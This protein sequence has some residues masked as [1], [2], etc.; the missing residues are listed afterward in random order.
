MVE[1]KIRE[2]KPRDNP[3]AT[4]DAYKTIFVGRLAYETTEKRLER[5]MASFGAVAAVKVVRDKSTAESRGYGFVEFA[6]EEGERATGRTEREV[7]SYGGVGA[8]QHCALA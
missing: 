1:S 2:W 4:R 7:V 3:D 6:S 5:E 8:M